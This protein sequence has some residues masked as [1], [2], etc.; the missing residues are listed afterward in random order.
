VR[1][2]KVLLP[3]ISCADTRLSS[4]AMEALACLHQQQGPTALQ[5]QLRAAGGSELLIATVLQA[6]IQNFVPSLN[7][8][9]LVLHKLVPQTNPQE[10]NP[11]DRGSL[12]GWLEEG[13]GSPAAA[14]AA[15]SL[16]GSSG[17]AGLS[18]AAGGGASAAGQLS[19]GLKSL[20]ASGSFKG[21]DAGGGVRD[22]GSSS[23]KAKWADLGSP[24]E[25][26]QA[27][28]ILPCGKSCCTQPT[29]LAH[30][31]SC[32]AS[33][34]P[35]SSSCG[36]AMHTWPPGTVGACLPPADGLGPCL[37]AAAGMRD[38]C[39]RLLAGS[40]CSSPGPDLSEDSLS[41][42]LGMRMRSGGSAAH[43]HNSLN[44]SSG[45]GASGEGCCNIINAQLLEARHGVPITSMP[46][47]CV[48]ATGN[49]SLNPQSLLS[50]LLQMVH[51][52]WPRPHQEPLGVGV[53]LPRTFPK[54]G[55]LQQRAP[56]AAPA[57]AVD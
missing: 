57:A 7:A 51:Q 25:L 5:Q 12:E 54:A 22:I 36:A 10:I 11:M 53:I 31:R 42:S 49:H 16:L 32:Y 6:N 2:I 28:W 4:V 39:D 56:S 24:G 45:R 14:A 37:P 46:A 30:S 55:S 17:R 41:S 21:A 44:S 29:I 34:P 13:P 19:W 18:S 47:M 52:G 38:S 9:G 26:Q 27:P 35:W 43:L 3:A 15:A 48:Q 23:L 40:S 20:R 8:A 50:F 33:M 1:L